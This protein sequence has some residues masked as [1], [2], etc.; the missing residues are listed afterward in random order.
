MCPT[1]TDNGLE[2]CSAGCY[3]GRMLDKFQVHREETEQKTGVENLC[4][5]D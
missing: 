5:T 2:Y 4:F 1:F 3:A